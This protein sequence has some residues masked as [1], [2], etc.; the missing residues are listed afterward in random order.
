MNGSGIH[1][2]VVQGD[3]LREPLPGRRADQMVMRLGRTP[4][5]QPT[6]FIQTVRVR[7]TCVASDQ[8]VRSSPLV[9]CPAPLCDSLKK[10]MQKPIHEWP[11]P[12]MNAE[13]I[14][15]RKTHS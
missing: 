7:R 3:F 5:V 14:H 8:D 1:E 13:P 6:G 11:D 9:Q 12:F 4:R 2:W 10:S 15:E